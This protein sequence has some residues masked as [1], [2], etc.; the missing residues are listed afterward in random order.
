MYTTA[1]A[2]GVLPER[3][4]TSTTMPMLQHQCR[5][6]TLGALRAVINRL[7]LLPKRDQPFATSVGVSCGA[8]PR[9]LRSRSTPASFVPWCSAMLH[10][11]TLAT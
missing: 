7:C 4:C 6:D 10:V 2:I 9:K 11:L 1:W 3:D 8:L 5:T